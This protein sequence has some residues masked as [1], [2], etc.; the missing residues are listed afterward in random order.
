MHQRLRRRTNYGALARIASALLT[1]SNGKGLVLLRC[2]T[3]PAAQCESGIDAGESGD[4]RFERADTASADRNDAV[5]G[6]GHLDQLV[7]AGPFVADDAVD[8]DDVAAMNTEK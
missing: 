8:V 3:L 2:K 7:I 5:A 6:A 1:Q 4:P